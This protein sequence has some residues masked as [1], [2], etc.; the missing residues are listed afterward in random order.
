MGVYI[1]ME[2]PRSCDGCRFSNGYICYA[3][4]LMTDDNDY[5]L[6][7][8]TDAKRHSNCPLIEIP[9]PHGRLIDA[10]RIEVIA[11]A[12]RGISIE[13]PTLIEPEK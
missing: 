11:S 5:I 9:T 6:N 13:A 12:P 1:K 7:E 8:H 4:G 2:M 10:D 3:S